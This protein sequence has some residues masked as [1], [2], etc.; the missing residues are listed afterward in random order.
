MKHSKDIRHFSDLLNYSLS[1]EKVGLNGR[2]LM[3][4][5][6]TKTLKC[7]LGLL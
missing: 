5:D 4:D 7:Y 1:T 3:N 6:V 2:V